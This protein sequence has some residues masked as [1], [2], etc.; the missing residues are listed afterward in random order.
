MESRVNLVSSV[1][2]EKCPVL[3]EI[4]KFKGG[5]WNVGKVA[6][7]LKTCHMWGRLSLDKQH[8]GLKY[9]FLS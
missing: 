1:G 2:R 6:L 8:L 5:F 3:R 7:H 4:R 9:F